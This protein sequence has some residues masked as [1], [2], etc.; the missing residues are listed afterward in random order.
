MRYT[1]GT[2]QFDWEIELVAIIS[3]RGKRIPAEPA[4]EYM[5]ACSIGVDRQRWRE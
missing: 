4:M 3:T 2:D 5:G 1:I